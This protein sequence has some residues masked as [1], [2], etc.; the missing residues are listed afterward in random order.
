MPGDCLSLAVGVGSQI[1]FIRFFRL[2]SE[3]GE[4]ISFSSYGDIFGLVVMFDIY[5]ELAFGQVADVS[6]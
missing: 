2:F 3:L 4:D 1:H 5:T 6:L